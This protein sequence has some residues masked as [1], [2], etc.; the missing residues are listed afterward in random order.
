M[1]EQNLSRRRFFG[2]TT[3]GALSA[4][5]QFRYYTLAADA[6]A[7]ARRLVE[8]DMTGAVVEQDEARHVGPCGERG[9][10]CICRFEAAD[11]D[12]NVHEPADRCA[13][14]GKIL[15]PPAPLRFCGVRRPCGFRA[16][17]AGFVAAAWR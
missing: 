5:N 8:R 17:V 16:P 6:G 3:A 4:S 1:S 13:I 2:A 12:E 7:E 11:L 9:V 14:A 15:E 10:D